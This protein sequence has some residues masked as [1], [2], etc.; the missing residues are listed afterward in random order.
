[1]LGT[2]GEAGTF[3]ARHHAGLGVSYG[4]FEAMAKATGHY[5]AQCAEHGWQPGPDDILYR[6]NMVL[7]ETDEA[8]EEALRRRDSR[9]PFPVRESLQE[10]LIEADFTRNIAGRKQPANVG[11]VLPVSFCGGPDRIVEQVRSC[12]EQIGAGVL[13]LSLQD[14]GAGNPEAMMEALDLFG[15]KVLPRIREI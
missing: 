3:A 13:D 6:A 8:A 9:A 7:G 11:G 12:R 5:R 10:A 2:S 15:R 14:P 4:S 1:V